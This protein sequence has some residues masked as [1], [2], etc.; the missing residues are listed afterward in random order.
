MNKD[1][2]TAGAVQLESNLQELI[3]NYLRFRQEWTLNTFGRSRFYS[4]E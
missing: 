4:L 1:N 2:S 3:S